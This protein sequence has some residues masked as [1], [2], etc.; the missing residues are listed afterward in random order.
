MREFTVLDFPTP[1][2][3]ISKNVNLRLRASSKRALSLLAEEFLAGRAGT[4]VFDFRVVRV[5]FVAFLELMSLTFLMQ[6]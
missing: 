6:K 2:L 4:S 1:V 3:P 5:I